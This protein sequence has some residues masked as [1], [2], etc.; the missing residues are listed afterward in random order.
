[1]KLLLTKGKIFLAA[2]CCLLFS[3]CFKDKVTRTYTLQ[4]P[5]FASKAAVLANIKAEAAHP[6]KESGKI[7]WFGKWIFMSDPAR[8]IHIIDNTN[9]AAPKAK[10]FIALPGNVD[11]AVKGNALY[12]DLFTDLLVLDINDPL[13]P[14]LKQT[15]KG[16]FPERNY[17]NGYYLDTSLVIVDWIKK[18]TTVDIDSEI[19]ITLPGFGCP[20]CSFA[21]LSSGS[22]KSSDGKAGSMARLALVNENLFL[23]N[24]GTLKTYS[25]SSIFDPAFQADLNLGWGIETVY[26]FKD[27]L[28]I[29]SNTGMFIAD[30]QNPAQPQLLGSFTHARACDPVVADDNYAYVTL[31]SGNICTGTTNQLDILDV[32]NLMQ[33]SLIKSFPMTN[34]HGLGLKDEF[35]YLCDGKAGL[36]VY[37][38]SNKTSIK[39]KQQLDIAEAFDIILNGNLALVVGKDGLYQFQIK[40]DGRLE[41]LSHYKFS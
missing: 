34:P 30:I 35:V 39:L 18:D 15:V 36:K 21:E 16:A 1:M 33:P 10:A 28:F 14:V 31:R 2:C 20:N 26:P 32:S 6:I 41:F 29:G 27:K 5:V 25:I 13:N 3:S 9:P 38:V 11:I 24:T 40:T 8:G 7:Y 17:V 37:D 19:N 12:A 4:K 22:S 23:V